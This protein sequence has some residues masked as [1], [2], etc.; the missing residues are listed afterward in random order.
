MSEHHETGRASENVT[1]APRP[2]WTTDA[3]RWRE[4]AVAKFGKA[5]VAAAED[6][7]SEILGHK[8]V[9]AADRQWIRR[10][11]KKG[12][13]HPFEKGFSERVAREM[14]GGLSPQAIRKRVKR[15]SHLDYMK[16][17][18][19]AAQAGDKAAETKL[20][21]VL[22]VGKFNRL[23]DKFYAFVSAWDRASDEHH[24][25][26]VENTRGDLQDDLARIWHE[27]SASGEEAA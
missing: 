3:D 15:R 8:P 18:A 7:E 13:L 6:R 22:N 23:Y 1:D 17:L 4:Q 5:A 27:A 10:A 24:R 19:D 14:F 16:H 20:R 26:L 21:K 11:R 25:M 2:I 9:S 12:L